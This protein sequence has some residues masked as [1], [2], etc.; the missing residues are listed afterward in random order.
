M[1]KNKVNLSV[2]DLDVHDCGELR[3]IG[4]YNS[5]SKLLPYEWLNKYER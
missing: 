3:D 4:H 5:L 1:L 2:L